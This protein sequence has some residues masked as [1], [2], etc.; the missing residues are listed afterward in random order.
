M[1]DSKIELRQ[2]GRLLSEIFATAEVETVRK[3]RRTFPRAPE[4]RITT[5]FAAEAEQLV[6]E[7]TASR[8]AALAIRSDLEQAYS[9]HG[10]HPMRLLRLTDGL[11]A[12]V[13][14]QSPKEEGRTG[15]DFGLLWVAPTFQ[16]RWDRKLTIHRGERRGL[17]VQAKK[18]R[19]RTGWRRFTPSQLAALPT[20]LEY[21]ALLR[22]NIGTYQNSELPSFAWN[23]LAGHEMISAVEWLSSDQFPPFLTTGEILE[24]LSNAE[25]GTDDQSVIERDVCPQAGSHI[26]IEIDWPDDPRAAL[27]A[28]NREVANTAVEQ[29]RQAQFLRQG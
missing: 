12:R 19:S 26:V 17:L 23:P 15:A 4:D 13:R 20:R 29:Q 16:L 2:L 7:A 6:D 18:R 14:T 3:V 22:Y 1:H 25:L 5:V 9:L 21:A 27:S 8:R 10:L 24:K 28:L 11:I